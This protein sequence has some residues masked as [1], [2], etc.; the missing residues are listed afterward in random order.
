MTNALLELFQLDI[1]YIIIGILIILSS[2]IAIFNM[3][4]KFSRMIG[5]PVKWIQENEK[6]HALLMQTAES[7]AALHKKH[8]E[9]IKRSINN[10]EDFRTELKSLIHM[11]VDKEINDYR[12]EIINLADKISNE[13]NISKECYKHALSIYEKYEKIIKEYGKT[14][15]E[16]EISMGIIKESY[17]AKLK[18]GF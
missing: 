3:I 2:M 13:Q 6:D 7:L 5:K 4:E 18:E 15:G 12:W 16:V 14:N 1:P 17:Q 8:E 9:D 10:D 11:F